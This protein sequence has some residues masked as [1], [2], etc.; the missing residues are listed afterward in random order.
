[1]LESLEVSAASISL[2]EVASAAA[3]QPE[4]DLVIAETDGQPSKLLSEIQPSLIESGV[5]ALLLI[6]GPDKVKGLRL[7]M[8]L[9]S[10][11]VV[12]NASDDELLTR[13]GLLIWPG[14]ETSASDIVSVDGMTINLATYQVQIDG[15]PV[16]LTYLEYALLAFLAT[17]PGKTYSRD[18]LLKRV[19]GFDYYGGSR[20]ID[21]HVRRIR[22]KL[23]PELAQ[24]L[25]TIRG[26]GY[27]WNS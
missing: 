1:M 6:V 13:I 7:P 23:G 5:K 22:A 14:N 19:W 26:V 27:L 4:T 24:H 3:E 16:D 8:N 15:I 21:V 12:E 11:F 20:T 17:H 25:Q 18:T 10:D 9:T 2:S